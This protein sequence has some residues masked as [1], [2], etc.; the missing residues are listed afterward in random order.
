MGR[1][2]G[3]TITVKVPIAWDTMTELKKQRLRQIVGRD[4]RIIR[5]FLGVIEQ[6]ESN[7]LSG[8]YKTRINDGALDHLTITA[9]HVASK[10]PQRLEV[11]HDMKEKFPRCSSGELIEC[12][13]TA[14]ALYESYLALRKRR[15]SRSARPC[16]TIKS[17]RI[18]RWIYSL[19]FR[20]LETTSSA[21]RWWLDL[22]DSFDSAPKKK[23]I[24]DRIRIPLK[25]CQFHIGQIERGKIKAL[26][27]IND[28]RGRWWVHFAVRLNEDSV[29]AEGNLP[30]AVLGI[31]LGIKK[32]AC[33]ALITPEKV[34]ETRYF[35]QQDKA[36]AIEKYDQLV[37]ELQSEM[38][39]R[40]S[41]HQSYDNI[42]K[43]LR[44]LKSKRE[45]VSREY[46]LL[47][48]R[49]LLQYIIQ[50]SEKHTLYVALGRLKHIRN[51]ARRGSHTSLSH[52]KMIN[53]WSFAR[54]TNGLKHQ[55]SQLGW[56]VDGKKARYKVVSEAWTSSLCWKC[57]S[58]GRRPKQN[59]FVCPS[60]GHETNADRNGAINIA[61]RL[62]MLT[63]SLHSVRGRGKWVDSVN[64]GKNP[65]LMSLLQKRS[66]VSDSRE[67]AADHFVQSDLLNFGDE[68][69]KS[70]NDPAVE[71]TVEK[72]SVCGNDTPPEIQEKE[73]RPVGG[74]VS[75]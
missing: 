16:E 40:R 73:T 19:K 57:S 7:L 61:A 32:A 20:L 43:R 38:E 71:R 3:V 8:R 34:R 1:S 18:P 35:V 10:Y 28:R 2:K 72:L 65:Q 54:I 63:D 70:E 11:L 41:R 50:L 51:K 68:S 53:S 55:L 60:C 48:L 23:S 33:T 12:R 59:H 44:Q 9:V 25:M 30:P 5:S 62:I 37:A 47:L 22:Q 42:A 75:Q 58:R 4:T 29:S 49:E 74:T 13:R 39:S 15:R 21:S 26:Q 67:S 69:E 52:R 36:N 17:G 56:V 46:D 31:D 64:T 24:H 14:I 27:L 45:D 66:Y 6:H